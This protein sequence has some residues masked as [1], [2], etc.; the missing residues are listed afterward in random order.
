MNNSNPQALHNE[1]WE[2]VTPHIA[3]LKGINNQCLEL[4]HRVIVQLQK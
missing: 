1:P 3:Y 2:T 4:N